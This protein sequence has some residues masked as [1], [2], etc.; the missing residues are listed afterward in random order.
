[1]GTKVSAIL[2]A[3]V[4]EVY[5][6]L[7]DAA[8]LEARTAG[9]GQA[10]AEAQVAVEE[11]EGGATI[12]KT[13]TVELEDMP[14]FLKKAFN[15][16]QTV[17]VKESWNAKGDGFEGSYHID[18]QGQ[19]VEVRGAFSLTPEGDGARYT[20]ELEAKAKIPIIGKQVAKFVLGQYVQGAKD[21]L[22]YTQ[23]HLS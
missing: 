2:P 11:A 15:P 5:A 4:S 3:A 10:N 12:T 19:P 17:G 14:A 9:V 13:I 6:V 18:I 8:F 23:T 21:E 16:S 1:M 20:V 7:T 22:A